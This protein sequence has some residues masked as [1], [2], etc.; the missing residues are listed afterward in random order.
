MATL[1]SA[2]A[3]TAAARRRG[4]RVRVAVAAG[5]A[6]TLALVAGLVAWLAVGLWIAPD[7]AP[8]ATWNADPEAVAAPSGDEYEQY[9]VDPTDGTIDGEWSFRNDGLVP[10]V[11]RIAPIAAPDVRFEARLRM[12]PTDGGSSVADAEVLAVDAGKQFGV[13]YSMAITCDH[14]APGSVDSVGIDYVMIEVTRLGLTRT[15]QVSTRG[16]M[17]YGL[18]NRPGAL[19]SCS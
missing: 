6:V 5:I 8:G 9:V 15:V 7:I 18:E 16:A 12:I 13:A 4:R 19:R 17:T 11:V 2:R 3:A 14:I 1:D 10:V